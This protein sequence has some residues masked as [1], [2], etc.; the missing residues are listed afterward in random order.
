MKCKFCP[1]SEFTFGTTIIHYKTSVGRYE[2]NKY[3]FVFDQD[4]SSVWTTEDQKIYIY[5]DYRVFR[6]VLMIMCDYVP[7]MFCEGTVCIVLYAVSVL[8][9]IFD[10]Y[11]VLSR[12]I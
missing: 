5:Q 7:F 9:W 3:N 8:V 1:W 11:V 10:H 6:N 12:T 2:Y 4:P